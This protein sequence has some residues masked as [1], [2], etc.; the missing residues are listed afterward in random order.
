MRA[1]PLLA[2]L[3]GLGSA[4]KAPPPR[5]P[6]QDTNWHA[7]ALA[8][9]WSVNKSFVKDISGVG[10]EVVVDEP[11]TGGWAVEFGVRYAEGDGDGTR[12]VYN[13]DTP[14]SPLSA[15]D[16][17]LIV[18]SEREIQFYEIDFGVRQV[19]RQDARFQPYFGV[20][21]ALLQSRSEERFVQPAILGTQ[22]PN[23]TPINDHERGEIRPGIYMR[24]GLV[25][26]VLKDQ[27]AED[28]EFPIAVDVR[29]LMSVDYSYLEVSLSVG[30][31]K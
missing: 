5:V 31:G 13:P 17:T 21:G 28:Y 7:S 9:D 25:W 11:N 23:D 30:Y 20:G 12:S 2:V 10:L 19:F 6:F 3:L 24:S 22:Y 26:N 4:C 1:A 15:D 18:D 16:L 14:T 8:T 27:L 29:G